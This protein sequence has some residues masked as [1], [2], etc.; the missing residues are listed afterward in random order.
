M[1]G[2]TDEDVMDL[3]TRL[4]LPKQWNAWWKGLFGRWWAG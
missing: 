1:N 4:S 3:L 2:W